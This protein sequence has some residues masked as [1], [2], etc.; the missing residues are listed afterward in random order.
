MNEEQALRRMISPGM[1]RQGK[2]RGGVIQIWTTRACDKSCFGCT[3]GSNLG[4]KLSF[5][6]LN[7]FRQAC[8]SLRDYFGIVG[9]FGGNPA[10]HPEFEDLC[11]ILQEVIPFERRGLWSNN[12]LGKGK[13]MRETF[14]PAVSNLNVHLDQ[15]AY[16]EFRRDWPESRPFG[17]DRDSRHSPVYVA[18]KDI[19]TDEGERWKL[20]SQ[21]DINQHWSAM[22]GVFRGELRGWFCEI[23][24]S[25]AML[26]QHDPNYPDTGI[27]LE[28][29]AF[30]RPMLWWQLPMASFADQVRLHCHACGVPLRGHGE[31]AQ[32]SDSD[33]KEFVTL[34]HQ[35]IYKPK[36]RERQVELVTLKEQLGQPLQKMTHYIQN[37]ENK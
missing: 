4:G 16:D 28:T 24:G 36:R 15:N 12:P 14:N 33:G 7:H 27:E 30:G 31:L 1:K 20:I 32:A 5:I 10:I 8:E 3:Q 34:T 13:I 25:Q 11:K 2:P 9:V 37:G 19:I 22:I 17:L 29:T 18:M 21:C 6:S 26:H 23:A 35:E